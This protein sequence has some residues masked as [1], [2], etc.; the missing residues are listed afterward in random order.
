M[1][2]LPTIADVRAAAER[3]RDEAVRTP[4][5]SSHVLDEIAGARVL[6]KAENLQRTGSFKFRGAHNAVVAAGD[7]ARNGVVACSSGNHA[8][9][10]AEA[11]RIRGVPATI[12]MPADAP[13]DK[14]RRTERAGAAVVEYDRYSEDREAIAAQ[15]AERDGALFVHPY[16]NP[17]VIAGQGTCGLEIIEDLTAM[18]LVPAGVLVCTGGGGLLGGITL[19]VRDAFPDAQMIAVEP[20]GFDDYGRSLEAGE[21]LGNENGGRSVCDAI[22]T[23][24]PGERSFAITHGVA[25][26]TSVTDAQALEAVAFAAR[27]LKMV[28]EPGGAVALAAI[29][30]EGRVGNLRGGDASSVFVATLSGGNIDA[31]MLARAVE[32]AG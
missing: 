13:A 18:G 26:G 20:A 7:A 10:I 19:A 14:K 23:P 27:E 4:L 5:V 21:R 28:V 22:L 12:V 32:A 2:D 16:E 8:Q 30:K 3:I 15:I 29:L 31:A 17:H 24:Q 6:L 9:G 11:A 25:W 1:S